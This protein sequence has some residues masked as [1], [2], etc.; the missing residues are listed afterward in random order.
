MLTLPLPLTL[1]LTLTLTLRQVE[2]L[3]E[4][5]AYAQDSLPLPLMPTLPLT[6]TLSLTL[7]LTLTLSLTLSQAEAELPPYG[8]RPLHGAHARA[9]AVAS[10]AAPPQLPQPPMWVGE[11]MP[12]AKVYFR[13]FDPTH[14]ACDPTHRL[15][16]D[17]LR[18][19]F[20]TCIFP[21]SP[22]H[23]AY[24]SP[25]GLLPS[26][27]ALP[28][29]AQHHLPTLAEARRR[30]DSQPG[31]HPAPEPRPRA[32]R[33]RCHGAGR[34]LT[35]TLTLTPTPTPTLTL[36]L[37]LPLPLPLTQTLPLPLPLTL[38]LT[39]AVAVALT[40]TRRSLVPPHR[41]GEQRQP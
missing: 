22:L 20:L 8:E 32:D 37:P 1:A 6:L 34:I 35:R 18:V 38:T 26:L 5:L 31:V 2:R 11:R 3:Q 40:L 9:S 14:P 7:T 21:T 24:I 25:A 12:L 27:R 33:A 39:L 41:A 28:D 16:L 30:P 36:P 19:Y 4:L 10:Q 17:S 29:P 15:L 23:L 13:R